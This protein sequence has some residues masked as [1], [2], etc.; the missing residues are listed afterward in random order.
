MFVN[1]FDNIRYVCI[2]L[3]NKTKRLR[4]KCLK[5]KNKINLF[6]LF[7][8]YI[9]EFE[10]RDSKYICIC[11]DNDDKYMKKVF[12]VWREEREIRTKFIVVDSLEINNYVERFNQTLMRKT[13]IIIKIANLIVNLWSKI[14]QT[15][16]LYRNIALVIERLVTSFEANIEYLYNYNYI[17]RID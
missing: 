1:E 14:I 10:H 17:R 4:V 12:K 11:I 9:D 5:N 6:V 15:T 3:N 8:R 13:N 7:K 16:N 2:W